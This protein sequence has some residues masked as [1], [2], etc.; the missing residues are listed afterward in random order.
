[1]ILLQTKTDADRLLFFFRVVEILIAAG[2]FSILSGLFVK[3]AVKLIAKKTVKFSKAFWI[4]FFSILA[5]F[6]LDKILRGA[7]EPVAVS[8]LNNFM[9]AEDICR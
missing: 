5:A 6:I 9:T 2:L 7:G 4:S 3:L 8:F 1:M